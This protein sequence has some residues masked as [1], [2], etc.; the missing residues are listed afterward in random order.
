MNGQTRSVVLDA[1]FHDGDPQRGGAQTLGFSAQG[2]IKRSK[3]GV[4]AW[5]PF[6]G[7]EVQIVIEAEL[8]KG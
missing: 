7:D 5:R 2:T 8:V 1:T 4:T 6:V 3:W